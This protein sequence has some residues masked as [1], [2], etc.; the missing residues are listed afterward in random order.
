MGRLLVAFAVGPVNAGCSFAMLKLERLGSGLTV[1]TCELPH[2]ESVCLGIWVGVGGRYEPKEVQGVSHFI[3]HMLFKGTPA[4]SA[5]ELSEKVEGVGGYM[6]AYT[7]EDHTCFH[8]K[9]HAAKW[10]L[11][12]DVLMDMF[13]HSSFSPEEIE[14]ERSVIKEE[15]A[16]DLDQPHEYVHDLLHETLWPNHP[17]GRSL[18]GTKQS[19]SRLSREQMLAFRSANYVAQ[20]TFIIA[21]GRI[22][23]DELRKAVM[24]FENGFLSGK[25]PVYAP[26]SS[27]EQPLQIRHLKKRTAQAQLALGFR[28]CSRHDPRR[29][30]LKLLSTILGENMSSRLFQSVREEKALAYSIHSSLSLYDDTGALVIA[31]GLDTPALLPALKLIVRELRRLKDESPSNAEVRRARDYVI[32]QMALNLEGTENQL[33]WVGEQLLAYGK[34]APATVIQAR[35]QAVTP[36]QI[37]AVARDFLYSARLSA[38]LISR[39]ADITGMAKILKVL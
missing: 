11:L 24:R 34:V 1:A 39:D 12:L 32:G 25:R 29:F 36:A 35:L 21:A 9:A 7:C 33:M 8:A 30:A 26:A 14:K 15:L 16:M 10:P 2:M 13:Q 18:T 5:R 4:R 17:L 37:R 38:A 23:A 6:N 31:A 20:N 28:T 22:G 27:P 19:L 3:E